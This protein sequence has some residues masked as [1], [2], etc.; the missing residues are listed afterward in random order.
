MNYRTIKGFTLMEMLIVIAIIAVLVAIAIPVFSGQMEKAKQATDLANERGAYAAALAE[1]MTNDEG[2]QVTYYYDSGSIKRD[3]NGISGY[4]QS[5]ADASTF[6]GEIDAEVSGVPNQDGKARYLTV[7]VTSDGAVSL[8]WAG[9]LADWASIGAKTI[10]PSKDD[11][12]YGWQNEYISGKKAA[13]EA[14]KAIDNDERTKADVGIL[15]GI[16]DYFNGMTVDEAKEILGDTKF[17]NMSKGKS[18]LMN[19]CVDGAY[20]MR[21]NPDKGT[22][23]ASYLEGIGYTPRIYITEDGNPWSV[24]DSYTFKGNNY[25]DTY[26]FTSDDAI[27]TPDDS[28]SNI[29]LSFKVVDGKLTN[30]KVMI[31][32]TQLQSSL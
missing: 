12:W 23:S 10:V 14:L 4:G 13:Y 9:Y 27:Q 17:E 32:G 31:D 8:S 29:Y 7:S 18:V 28:F 30:S 24:S 26:L 19:Y 21:L 5:S 20:S 6:S 2:K 3:M 22:K 16:A 15:N 1:W 11:N 25:V